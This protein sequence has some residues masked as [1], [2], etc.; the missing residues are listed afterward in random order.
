VEL[1]RG[2]QVAVQ[3][4]GHPGPVLAD[5]RAVD[6]ELVVQYLHGLLG[7][8]RAEDRP[9]R[10]ARQYRTREEDDQAQEDQGEQRQPQS[11]QNVPRH[12]TSTSPVRG[13]RAW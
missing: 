10:V 8:E 4:A 7:G 2:A 1:G 5:Q 3:D 6:A 13:G 12:F 9:A 11:L